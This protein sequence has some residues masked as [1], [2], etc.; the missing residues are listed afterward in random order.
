MGPSVTHQG[1]YVQSPLRRRGNVVRQLISH[2]QIDEVENHRRE[3]APLAL[4]RFIRARK[5]VGYG[6]RSFLS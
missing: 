5:V 3:A 4:V 2:V 6:E 1:M